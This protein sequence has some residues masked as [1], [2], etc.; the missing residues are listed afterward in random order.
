MAE[1]TLENAVVAFWPTWDKVSE[2]FL[3]L[4]STDGEQMCTENVY[5]ITVK[6]KI[7]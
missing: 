3:Y 6:H 5:N 1:P 2:V 7:V 4:S